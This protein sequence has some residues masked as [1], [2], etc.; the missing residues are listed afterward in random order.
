MRLCILNHACCVLPAARY[1]QPRLVLMDESTSALDTRNERLLYTALRG[2]G[3]TFVSVGHRPTLT[4]YHERVLLLHGKGGG[5]GDGG[6][7]GWEVRPAS[8]LPLEQA[9]D[10][11]G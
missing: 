1:L 2:A 10:Y 6:S 7:G 5:R 4:Q 3:I 8:E 9:I 11:I